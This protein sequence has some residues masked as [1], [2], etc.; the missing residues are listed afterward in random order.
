MGVDLGEHPAHPVV[1][2]GHG[3]AE[4][5]G[6]ADAVAVDAGEAPG[7]LDAGGPQGVEVEGA[8]VGPADELQR[9]VRGG[10]R[11]G[12]GSS[13]MLRSKV[14]IRSSHQKMSMPR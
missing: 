8:V 12:S 10:R 5:G 11:T 13:S 6:E 2:V 1:G 4:V 9:T 3:A 7:Q 14:P